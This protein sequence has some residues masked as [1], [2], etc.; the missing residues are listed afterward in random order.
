MTV[1]ESGIGN[2]QLRLMTMTEVVSVSN[3]TGN[4]SVTLKTTPRLVNEN[5]TACGARPGILRAGKIPGADKQV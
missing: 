3:T 1:G 2:K 4:Y 5:C